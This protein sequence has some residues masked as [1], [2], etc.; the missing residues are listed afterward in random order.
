VHQP[1]RAEDEV[2]YEITGDHTPDLSLL[3]LRRALNA[4]NNAFADGA[5]QGALAAR[6]A[7]DARKEADADKGGKQRRKPK[8]GDAKRIPKKGEGDR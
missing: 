1:T 5:D 7:E 2:E 4:V 6:S 8:L 3:D